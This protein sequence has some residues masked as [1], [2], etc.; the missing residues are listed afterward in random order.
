MRVFGRDA[1]SAGLHRK[2]SLDVPTH[3]HQ[4]PFAADVFQASQQ[5]LAITH[6]EFDDAEHRFGGLLA[7]R[8]ELSAPR[9]LQSM[10]HLLH[11]RGRF[12]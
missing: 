8:I 11:R 10:R 1:L 7:Q 4:V 9:G 12:R 6:H 2:H 5:T 3:G